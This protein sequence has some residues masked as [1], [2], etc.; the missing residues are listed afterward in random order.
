MNLDNLETN[1][2]IKFRNKSLLEQALRHRSYL[3]EAKEKNLTSNERLEFLGDA[4]A[5]LIISSLLYQKFPK[6][7]EGDLTNLRSALVRT[8][9]FAEVAKN[10][11]LGSYLSL[12]RGEEAEGGRQNPSLLA[13]A[14]EALLGAIYLDSGL[15]KAKYFIYRHL[16]PFL[17]KI[18]KERSL[19]D[20]KSLL[21]E[22]IQS[23]KKIT[24][25]YK[26]VE[27]TGP[28][29]D[30]TFTV[31]VLIGKKSLAIGT[32]RSKQIAEQEA[33]REALEKLGFIK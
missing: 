27:I 22:K 2:G 33:A 19:K 21:Q 7:P 6:A 10:L 9:T 8:Q 5:S 29:H 3:N 12:S 26:V 11:D 32:G 30:R 4:V 20:F 23:V 17:P 1:I 14:L 16:L 18:L 24:P 25:V 13:D 28:D 15:E 31:K